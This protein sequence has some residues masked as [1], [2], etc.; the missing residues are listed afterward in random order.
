M[1]DSYLYINQFALV[2]KFK[3]AII[4]LLI[5]KLGAIIAPTNIIPYTIDISY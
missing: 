4:A 2:D 5:K 1:F 3:S